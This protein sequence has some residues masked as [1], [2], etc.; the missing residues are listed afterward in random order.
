[1]KK[2]VR[3]PSP[4][5]RPPSPRAAGRG[6]SWI[7][8]ALLFVC[9]NAFAAQPPTSCTNCHGNADMF[10]ANARAKVK[11]F[12]TD[13][14]S[15]IGLSCHNCHGGNPDPALSNDPMAAMDPAFKANPYVGAPK[16]NDIPDFCGKC[17]SNAAFMKQYNPAARVDQVSEYWSSMHGRKLKEGDPNV[18]TCVDCHSVHDIRRKAAQDSPVFK[19]HVA[20]TCSRCHSDAKKMAQYGIHT[21][22]YAKWRVSVHA[23]ALLNK[24]DMAAPTCND[25]HG[26]HGASPPGVEAVSFVCGRCHAREAE[27]FRKSKKHEDWA[28][29]NA[30]LAGSNCATCHDGGARAKVTITQFSECVTCHENHG[31]IRPTVALLGILPDT[32]C[33]FCHEGVGPLSTRVA[34]VPAK[35]EHYKEVRGEF[36]EVA[37]KQHLEGNDRFDWLVDQALHLPFHRVNEA[38]TATLR[39]EF[40][41]LFEKF[42][43]G[44][45]HYTYTDVAT[46]KEVS[47][48]VRRCGDCH[49][50]ADSAGL[51]N[52]KAYVEATRGL[53]SMVGRADRILLTAH[54]G[55]V[56]VRK[57][58]AELDNAID[59]QIELETLVHTFG[60]EEVQAKQKEGLQHAE[61]ALVAGQASLDELSY[62]RRGLL[63]AV[64]VIMMVLLAL[65][66][67]IRM[68]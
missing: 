16:R 26:N 32:P 63:I 40:L 38:K 24:G 37:A 1:M 64:G 25:C 66:V 30:M 62:R 43:I 52:A 54:R 47:V 22:Q 15:Q 65:I 19:T 31:V 44:K 67:K 2:I 9:F 10:D 46:R 48:P 56:E 42:R 8:V 21:D 53:T 6:I 7:A 34:E 23:N 51:A 5:L 18:A 50:E 33:A 61:A 58:R 29:H 17:H 57:V 20:E 4:G 3:D 11:K 35:A 49:E 41:R 59:S 27:L 12:P 55:G 68:L 45:T 36:L 39:P 28:N 14:H 13:V 60:S